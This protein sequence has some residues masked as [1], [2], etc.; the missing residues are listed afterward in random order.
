MVAPFALDGKGANLA[1][2]AMLA[3]LSVRLR[4]ELD[5]VPAAA[6]LEA[7]RLD[8]DGARP[9]VPVRVGLAVDVHVWGAEAVGNL[10]LL[11]GAALDALGGGLVVGHA[12]GG[13]SKR[14]RSV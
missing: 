12:G 3:Q 11:L 6:V 10:H 8:P 7:Q 14:F 9:Q 1:P 2:M 4:L 13:E 5:H